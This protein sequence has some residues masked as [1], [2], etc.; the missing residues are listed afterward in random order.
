MTWLYTPGFVGLWSIV[1]ARGNQSATV[2]F[3]SETKLGKTAVMELVGALFVNANPFHDR[4]L[5]KFRSTVL[6]LTRTSS[7]LAGRRNE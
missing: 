7:D 6:E 1:S 4:G 5:P 2:V 3:C